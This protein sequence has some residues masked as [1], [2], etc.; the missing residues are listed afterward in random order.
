MAAA[1]NAVRCASR[2][3]ACPVLQGPRPVCT[4]GRG[5]ICKLTA[6]SETRDH[7][8]RKGAA[9]RPRS[10]GCGAA[11]RA[12]RSSH[13]WV[14]MRATRG[15]LVW[16]PRDSLRVTRLPEARGS[17]PASRHLGLAPSRGRTP[18][19]EV[20]EPAGRDSGRAA[21]PTPPASAPLPPARPR[22]PKRPR[23][24]RPIRTW[25]SSL[26]SMKAG[27]LIVSEPAPHCSTTPTGRDAG[28]RGLPAQLLPGYARASGAE[29]REISGAASSKLFFP[30]SFPAAAGRPAWISQ[31][32]RRAL[33]FPGR[34]WAAPR[35]RSAARKRGLWRPPAG[36]A[37]ATGA[38]GTVRARGRA[39][40]G[41]GRIARTNT[42]WAGQ[43]P[44]ETLLQT[45][46]REGLGL[47]I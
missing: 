4:A 29:L 22:V 11:P 13:F 27:T 3:R 2:L 43:R 35:L 30:G 41:R 23:P 18:R 12:G 45:K 19:R 10:T 39:E 14:G 24:G 6:T 40:P 15:H 8:A 28:A 16:P 31:Q 21:P 33:L 42:A 37:P 44:R 5:R 38:R 34:A 25:S 46:I 9:T 36:S 1:S 32:W 26:M 47:G 7:C 17:G 20:W